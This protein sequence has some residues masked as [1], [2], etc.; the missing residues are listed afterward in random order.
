MHQLSEG[1]GICQRRRLRALL[2]RL[3][4]DLPRVDLKCYYKCLIAAR[5]SYRTAKGSHDNA[6]LSTL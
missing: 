6:V 5:T 1:C 2:T 3:A 4:G